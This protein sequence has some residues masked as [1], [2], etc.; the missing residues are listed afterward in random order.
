MS[1]A[2]IMLKP[3]PHPQSV[4]NSPSTKVVPGAER[5]GGCCCA[6]L[7]MLSVRPPTVLF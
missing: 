7:L 3:S 5:L 4:E 1:C 2:G 6:V